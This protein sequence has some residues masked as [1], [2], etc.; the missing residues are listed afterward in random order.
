[1]TRKSVL[2]LGGVAVLVG[3]LGCSDNNSGVRLS[4][5]SGFNYRSTCPRQARGGPARSPISATLR[6][7]P[8]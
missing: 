6:G 3:A 8:V 4:S 5:G 7:P 1:M 2:L